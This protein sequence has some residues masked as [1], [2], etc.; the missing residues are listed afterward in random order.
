MRKVRGGRDGDDRRGPAERDLRRAGQLDPASDPGPPR[1]RRSDRQRA[2]RAVR[3][4]AAGGLQA[5]QGAGARRVGPTRPPGPVP[6]VRPRRR[7]PPGDLDVGRAVPPGLG[8][9]LR[10]DGRVPHAAPTATN[11]QDHDDRRQ[12][13]PGCG[14]D[15]A[16]LRRTG[17]PHLADVDRPASTSPPGTA[18]TAPPSP[19]P[20]WTCA[21]AA[22]DWCRMEVQTPNGPMQMWFTGEYR[23]VVENQRLVYTES[24]SDET[25]HRAVARRDGHARRPSDHHRD[26]RRARGRRR[27]HED[28]DDPRRHPRRVAGRRRLGDGASASS[29]PVSRHTSTC[30]SGRRG[31][32]VTPGRGRGRCRSIAGSGRVGGR[33]RCR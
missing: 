13:I 17:G 23:E 22:P 15:R 30:R 14:R 4:D 2:R 26:P 1:R 20:R 24:M 12:R 7:A 28:G 25:R 33:R 9:P 27:P 3:P 31:A 19:S 10:P 21:S 16:Q 8:G 11:G 6:A 29:R 18:P 32:P 5:H